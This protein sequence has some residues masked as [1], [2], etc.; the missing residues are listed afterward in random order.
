ISRHLPIIADKPDLITMLPVSIKPMHRFAEVIALFHLL[1][2]TVAIDT[3]AGQWKISN[4]E[5]KTA[6][7]LVDA[8]QR[9]REIGLDL[10]LVYRLDEN[11]IPAFVRLG[12]NLVRHFPISVTEIQQKKTLI[13]IHSLKELDINGNDLMEL[14]PELRKGAWIK[15][16]L[17]V[18]ERK[19][20]VGELVN[21][22]NDLKE[23]IIWN[24]P[25]T[26]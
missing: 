24:P 1:N 19:V 2:P 8:W 16:C 18:L 10:W 20:V 15:N 25:V 22:K 13:P 17:A 21:E 6:M 11:L 7:Q 5:K 12:Q 23:W 26:S 14:F 9:Y 4:K 3:W